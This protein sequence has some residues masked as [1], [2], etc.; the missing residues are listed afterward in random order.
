MP[1]KTLFSDTMSE[2]DFYGTMN[3]EEYLFSKEISANIGSSGKI[4]QEID[5]V[6]AEKII[7]SD[8]E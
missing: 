4:A 7:S 2:E 3:S 1:I 6:M 8:G 5:N